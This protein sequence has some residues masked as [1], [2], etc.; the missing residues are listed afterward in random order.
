MSAPL[1]FSHLRLMAQS[2][3][4]FKAHVDQ[5]TSAMDVG[6]AAHAIVLGGAPVVGY[7]DGKARR[8]KEWDAFKAD[9]S[10]E[11]IILTA[12]ELTQAIEMAASVTGNRDAM[13]ALDGVREQTIVWT[14]LWRGQC[15]GTPDVLGDGFLTELK[16]GET[17]DPR[18]FPWKLKQFAYHAQLAW[19]SI[20]AGSLPIAPIRDYNIV[21]V[22]SKAP[23]VVT[24][25]KIGERT[26]E[27]GRKLIHA[28]TETLMQ[29]T[30]SNVWPG[31]ASSPVDLELP[32][33]DS[34]LI[35]DE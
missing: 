4:H 27:Q 24:V 13:K 26:I 12:R 33:H 8:G 7:E 11:T 22:E 35:F 16:T 32:D 17:S 2:A 9:Y 15:R 1:R 31:Y 21:A 5:R 18:R 14:D 19:Y 28:W 20:A 23:Y 10:P 30:R 29:C 6:T 25:F 34:Q 3:A